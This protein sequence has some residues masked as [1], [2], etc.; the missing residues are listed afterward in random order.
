MPG[1]QARTH[2]VWANRQR[3]G[4]SDALGAGP[5]KETLRG[6]R[7]GSCP[8]RRRR[9][10]AC[11]GASQAASAETGDGHRRP[12]AKNALRACTGGRQHAASGRSGGR[13]RRCDES[14]RPL[15]VR[16]AGDAGSRGAGAR[17]PPETAPRR[18]PSPI[19]AAPHG[20]LGRAPVSMRQRRPRLCLNAA[21]TTG[22]GNVEVVALRQWGG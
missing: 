4:K 9:C 14:G 8:K 15:R 7:P 11:S 19:L 20:P 1:L 16:R 17:P 12:P 10:A 13:G 5:G 21:Q 22:T 6:Q 2:A 18:P 3:L